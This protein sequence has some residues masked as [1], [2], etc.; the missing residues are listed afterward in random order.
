MGLDMGIEG[1]TIELC[2][3][4]VYI[5]WEDGGIWISAEENVHERRKRRTIMYIKASRRCV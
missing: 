3:A 1:L 5:L 4:G 2:E